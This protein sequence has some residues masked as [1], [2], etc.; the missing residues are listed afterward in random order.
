MIEKSSY[1]I[2]KKNINNKEQLAI[3]KH[4]CKVRRQLYINLFK[5]YYGWWNWV[6]ICRT[7]G[8]GN[9]A[10]VLIPG[11]DREIC[12]YSLLYLDQ[13]LDKRSFDNAIILTRDP[14]V[15]TVASIFSKRILKVIHFGRKRAEAL[16]Q[17]YCLYEFNKKFICA[18]IDEPTGRNGT[19]LVGKKGT[20]KE[21]IFVIGVYQIY[22]FNKVAAPM[23]IGEMYSL[24]S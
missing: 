15:M 5:A 3:K 13:M 21:E 17:F 11:D 10:V 7:K 16:M 6:C 8:F 22:P 20:T 1:F 14:A 9:T 2:V 24:H 18:S 19:I 4:L 23:S 12:Y